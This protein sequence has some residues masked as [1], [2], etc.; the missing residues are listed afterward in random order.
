M[1]LYESEPFDA[2][3]ERSRH[4]GREAVR[5]A[6]I[7]KELLGDAQVFSQFAADCVDT[8]FTRE[9]YIRKSDVYFRVDDTARNDNMLDLE[10]RAFALPI[11]KK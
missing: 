5:Y 11:K 2:W 6:V 8:F 10:V 4:I 7:T 1:K 9:G 3:R